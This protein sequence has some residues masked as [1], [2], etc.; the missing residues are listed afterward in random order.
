MH[1]AFPLGFTGAE[2]Q[3]RRG[4]WRG[5]RSADAR[6]QTRAHPALRQLAA[7]DDKPLMIP[8]A[9][10]PPKT[11]SRTVFV[12]ASFSELEPG[13]WQRRHRLLGYLCLISSKEE[14]EEGEREE[15]GGGGG[16]DEEEGR[17]DNAL[18]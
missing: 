7:D 14:E 11:L 4:S 8:G 12:S 2:S 9:G 1:N 13:F 10:N 5:Q 6:P 18:E 16:E 17:D 15:G 3:P